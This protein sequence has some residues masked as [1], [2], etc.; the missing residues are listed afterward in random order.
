MDFVVGDAEL[1]EQYELVQVTEDIG[2]PK[3]DKAQRARWRRE[4]GS[5]SV[6]MR[7]CGLE[8]GTIVTLSDERTVEDEA[9]VISVVPAWKWCLGVG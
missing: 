6:A 9:G 8:R 3:G 1:E 5:L 2:D 4:V 7:L